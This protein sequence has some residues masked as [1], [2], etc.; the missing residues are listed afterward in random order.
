MLQLAAITLPLVDPVAFAIGPIA[1]KWYGLSYLAGLLL[2]WLYIARLLQNVP[3]WPAN[4]PPFPSIRVDDLLLYV[5]AGTI[6]GARLGFVLFYEPSF[7]LQ[8]PSQIPAIW[9]G[10]M[11]FH[12][13]L[14]GCAAAC[15][16]F[17]RR[18]GCN[19]YSVMDLGTAA[20]PI[21]LFFG[22]LANFINGE[23]YGRPTTM[24]WGMVFPDA[25]LLHPDIEPVLRHPSQLYQAAMEGLALFVVLRVLTHTFG[26]LKTPG[27]VTGTF[28]AGYGV[29]RCIGEMFREPHEGHPLNIGPLSVGMVYSIPMIIAGIM[30]IYSVRRR[31]ARDQ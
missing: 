19:P 30:I 26:A 12:G 31:A 14:I 2:G 11:A 9:K 22:R 20:V 17:A 29:A 18:L 28:L 6:I 21:G 25:A 16:L 27:L 3:L 7:Y 24:P 5:T 4:T 15:W 23:L 1:V 8:N 13:A 10:G